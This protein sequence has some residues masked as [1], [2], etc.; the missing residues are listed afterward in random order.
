MDPRGRITS[1]LE[2]L[3]NRNANLMEMGL[4]PAWCSMASRREKKV[5]PSRGAPGKEG[6][7]EEG[8]GAGQGRGRCAESL[9]KG[10]PV[11][12]HHQRDR[13]IVAHPAHPSRHTGGA[14]PRGRGGAGRPHVRQGRRLGLGLPRTSI[15]CC[16]ARLG[17]SGTLPLSGRR[18]MPGRDE[19]REVRMQIID[20]EETLSALGLNGKQ[21][22][23]LCIL[24]GT[25][26]N[27][28]V[29]GIGPKKALKLI[30]QH[31]TLAGALALAGHGGRE[32]EK[33]VV[34]LPGLRTHRRLSPGL[35][36]A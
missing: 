3:L 24:V 20:R 31:G 26:F 27:P 22:V 29:M 10:H 12:P 2:G 30:K 33:V 9:F 11:L 36:P 17:W 16:S 6:G 13:G 25:D 5:P 19:Y 32:M 8:M 21:L 18:K 4:R 7:G 23:D 15:R 1:H 34:D 35:E 28:G 14:G